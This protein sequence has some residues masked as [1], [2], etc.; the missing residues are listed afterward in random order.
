MVN[1]S[2]YFDLLLADIWTFFYICTCRTE[3]RGAT[4]KGVAN[5]SHIENYISFF[6]CWLLF[7]FLIKLGELPARCCG[8]FCINLYNFFEPC[9]KFWIK[10]NIM[11]TCILHTCEKAKA[12]PTLHRFTNAWQRSNFQNL[13]TT[14]WRYSLQTPWPWTALRSG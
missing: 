4:T 6:G 12:T 3:W 9:V 10:T 5:I 14:P 7:D 2:L 13:H 1:P 11:T 8:T